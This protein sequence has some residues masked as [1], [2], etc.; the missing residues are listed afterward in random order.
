[1]RQQHFAKGLLI[2]RLDGRLKKSQANLFWK[3]ALASLVSRT[4]IPKFI[5]SRILKK[6][7]TP[8]HGVSLIGQKVPH[9][10]ALVNMKRTTP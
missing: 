10:P 3:M 1:L 7:H 8:G 2:I 9:F 6:I 4:I 5:F